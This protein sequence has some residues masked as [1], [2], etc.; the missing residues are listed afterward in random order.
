MVE[1]RKAENGVQSVSEILRPLIESGDSRFEVLR[2]RHEGIV[3]SYCPWCA[4]YVWDALPS[5]HPDFEVGIRTDLGSIVRAAAAC[6]LWVRELSQWDGE[7]TMIYRRWSMGYQGDSMVEGATPEEAAARALVA[8]WEA[9]K[10][11]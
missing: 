2:C 3:D 11:A 10:D 4:I 8:A 5:E 6:G 9:M 1:A 7:W